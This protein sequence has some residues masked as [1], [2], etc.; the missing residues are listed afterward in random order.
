[1]GREGSGAWTNRSQHEQ[2]S[3]GRTIRE[4]CMGVILIPTLFSMLWFAVF[5]GAGLYIE[6]HGAGSLADI[7]FADVTQ[8]FFTFL[9][10]LP[11]AGLLNVL[12]IALVFIFLVTSTD[13]ST[14]VGKPCSRS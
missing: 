7:V 14:V 11:L 1:M 8:A 13:S 10:Y 3:R 2:V 9:N 4:F 5:G 6:L 12:A